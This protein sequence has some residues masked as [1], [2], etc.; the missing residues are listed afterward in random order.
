[1]SPHQSLDRNVVNSSPIAAES[2][3]ALCQRVER[4][5]R[6]SGVLALRGVTC[7][8][9]QGKLTLG[10]QVPSYYQKQLAQAVVGQIEGVKE[11]VNAITV[12][13]NCA[14]RRGP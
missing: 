4:H 9:H 7:E 8:L 3:E 12:E 2:A 11:L 5:L 13:S 14:P 1:M 10:G 6:G